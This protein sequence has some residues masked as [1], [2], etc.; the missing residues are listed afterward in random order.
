MDEEVC[1]QARAGSYGDD[2]HLWQQQDEYCPS[3]KCKKSAIHKTH[4]CTILLYQRTD[5]EIG[6]YYFMNPRIPDAS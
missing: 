2:H 1:K 3:K 4:Y 5:Q 6:T